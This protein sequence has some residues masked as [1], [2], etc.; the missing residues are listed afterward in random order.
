MDAILEM[1]N[2]NRDLKGFKLNDISLT[3]D[4][5]YVMGLIG[6]NGAGK[7]SVIKLIM[8]LLRKD[9]GSINVFGMD[10]VK[11]EAEVKDRIGFVYDENIFPEQ[12]CLDRLGYL[13][14]GF[15]SQWDQQQF[16]SYLKRFELN[17][18]SKLSKLSKGMKMKF[19][20]A[21]ALSHHAEL[22]IM[23]EPTS[24]LDPVFRRELL[25][26]LHYLMQDGERSI[27]F[28]THITSDLDRIADIITLM[29]RG[30]IAMSIPFDKMVEHYRVIKGPKSLV[31]KIDPSWLC[32]TRI[33]KFGFD[34]LSMEGGKIEREFG[35]AI[36]L[37][38]PS[39]EDVMIYYSG[40]VGEQ[41]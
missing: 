27:I 10:H 23:D 35:S 12:L 38:K 39:I 15:Y 22:I 2:V 5:G 6:A 7:T 4:K 31:E 30:R 25:D 26:I 17:P 24:G 21:A 11:N 1:K 16:D 34:A 3:L 41:A 8:N 13:L 19:S 28:S 9:S 32:G 33:N 36:V 29:D 14:S 20:I 40:K 37:E 18:R